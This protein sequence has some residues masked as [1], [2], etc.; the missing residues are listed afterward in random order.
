VKEDSVVL[1]ID[2]I[3]SKGEALAHLDGDIWFVRGALPHEKVTVRP[4]SRKKNIC[5]GEV[6]DIIERSEHR[7]NPFCPY[8]EVCGGCD[9]QHIERG[10][11]VALKEAIVLENLQRI[12]KIEIQEEKRNFTYLPPYV[13]AQVEYRKKV[14][15][16]VDLKENKVGFLAKQSHTVVDI[17]ECPVLS[18]PLQAFLSEKRGLLFERAKELTSSWTKE[19]VSVPAI[20]GDEDSVSIGDELITITCNG[21]PLYVNATVFFQAH[22]G[23]LSHM[24][25]RVKQWSVGSTI[26][27][28]YSGIGTFA[29]CVE[30][31]DKRVYAIEKDT[32]C[33]ALAKK[34][35]TH[36]TFFTDDAQRW[37]KKFPKQ[38]V[39]TIIV[40]PPRSG[41][42]VEVINSIDK[43]GPQRLIYI[44]CDSATFS[45]DLHLLQERG[46]T[47]D[48]LEYLEMYPQTS[49]TETMALFKRI[50]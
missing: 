30:G 26:I 43:I 28:L 44:S 47:L 22:Q 14:R 11:Q 9:M 21:I 31:E 37:I 12:G 38:E 35:L 23:V 18:E 5:R 3:V 48:T 50:T 16:Q 19:I 6:I 32:S 1:T 24:L 46:Y 27:D 36:T 15:F 40:D 34:H 49:H 10:E 29:S 45:R 39:G 2:K 4:V 7:V 20:H 13:D 8:Y 17:R 25:S 42:N 33:L 41:L